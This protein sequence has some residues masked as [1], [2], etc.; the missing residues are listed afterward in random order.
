[1]TSL[2]ANE[3]SCIKHCWGIY[4]QNSHVNTVRV[5]NW[6]AERVITA[7]NGSGPTHRN[8]NIPCYKSACWLIGTIYLIGINN[9]NNCYG[10]FLL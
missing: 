10:K 6:T 2:L 4:E 9:L 8:H 1:M 3:H 7:S 5:V